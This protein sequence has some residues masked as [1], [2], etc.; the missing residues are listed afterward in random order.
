MIREEEIAVCKV[1]QDIHRGRKDWIV[2]KERLRIKNITKARKTRFVIP[3]WV[4]KHYYP[5]HAP[6]LHRLIECSFIGNLLEKRK[7]ERN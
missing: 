3:M 1:I 2:K 7:C 4:A 5:R 6:P